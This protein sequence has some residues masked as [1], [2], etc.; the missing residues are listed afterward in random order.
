M[1]V[2]EVAP[3]DVSAVENQ[4]RD[5]AG[6]PPYAWREREWSDIDAKQERSEAGAVKVDAAHRRSSASARAAS[7][8]EPLSRLAYGI[9]ILLGSGFLL[10]INAFLA[11]IDFYALIFPGRHVEA[12]FTFVFNPTELVCLLFMKR[13]LARFD[14]APRCYLSFAVLF[15]VML[16]ASSVGP[17]LDCKILSPT[18]AFAAL[19]AAVAASGVC[20][21]VL[22]ASLFG[23]AGLFPPPYT[24]V[25]FKFDSS[26]AADGLNLARSNSELL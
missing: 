8:A 18:P 7:A 10:P 24:D 20:C 17:L 25:R 11:A 16:V 6:A 4:P 1:A 14:F 9:F 13:L 21:A 23:F 5:S 2:E 15:L 26:R 19:L 12:A 22:E 3:I